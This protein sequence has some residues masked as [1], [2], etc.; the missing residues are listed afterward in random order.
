MVAIV[1]SG[2]VPCLPNLNDGEIALE[3]Q[4]NE[5]NGTCTE[6]SI[7]GFAFTQHSSLLLLIDFCLGLLNCIRRSMTH[8]TP[9][10]DTCP[11]PLFILII[12]S[13]KALCKLYKC[14][15][16]TCF[17]FLESP[18]LQRGWK[19]AKPSALPFYQRRQI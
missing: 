12:K 16:F 9:A 6:S 1:L 17:T 10:N 5:C 2:S 11:P 8:L 13:V 4:H 19:N 14:Q 7:G 18:T 15:F 3:R